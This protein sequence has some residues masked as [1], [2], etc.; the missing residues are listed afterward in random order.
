MNEKKTLQSDSQPVVRTTKKTRERQKAPKTK[1][2][3]FTLFIVPFQSWYFLSN[4]LLC[5]TCEKMRRMKEWNT[6]QE[7]FILL[8]IGINCSRRLLQ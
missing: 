1:Q 4:Y 5:L 6:M 2:K 8:S 7:I 3:L